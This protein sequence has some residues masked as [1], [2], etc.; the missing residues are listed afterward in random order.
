MKSVRVLLTG[1]H[2]QLGS[3]IAR[4]MAA[5]PW[6]VIATT[7]QD[8]DLTDGDA[9]EALCQDHRFDLVINA[10]AYTAVDRAEQEED[11]AHRINATAPSRFAEACS[12]TGA[13]LI[14]VSTDYVFDGTKPVPYTESDPPCP[15]NTYGRSKEAGEAAIRDRLDR[16]LIVRTA[17]VFGIQGQNF[18]KTMLRLASEREEL[19]V[20]ADQQGNPTATRDLATAIV[21]L[22]ETIGTQNHGDIPWGTY[23]CVNDGAETWHGFAEAIVDQAA[24]ALGRRPIVTP[25]A[26]D[27]FPT[28]AK[29]PRNSRLDC[30]SLG[31]TFGIT[32]PHW[33]QSL[34]EVVD[35]VL[36]ANHRH[37]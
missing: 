2:G 37:P 16:H 31:E 3:E 20:V 34:P 17:W 33:R 30:T 32:M 22:A 29:R 26:T 10:A 6:D 11:L 8:L 36:H 5:Q 23:H 4:Q 14:H 13:A 25:I 24:T 28:P 35:H 19:R 27:D 21:A 18:V 9:I 15:I 1:A 12:R 7:R